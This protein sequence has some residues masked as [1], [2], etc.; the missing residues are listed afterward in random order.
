MSRVHVNY[1]NVPTTCKQVGAPTRSS[2]S[3]PTVGQPAPAVQFAPPGRTMVLNVRKKFT[4]Q[5]L[6]KWCESPHNVYVGRAGVVFIPIPGAPL[7][8]GKIKS[9]GLMGKMRV[10][11]KRYPP[12]SS[13]WANPFKIP[14][15][16]KGE[17]ISPAEIYR[18]H[19]Q[20]VSSYRTYIIKKIADDPSTYDISKLCDKNLGCWCAPKPCHADVLREICDRTC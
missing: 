2:V 18:R 5:D 17:I 16:K 15:V 10:Q 13:I 9:N 4:H 14:R 1:A 6:N 11:R 12:T 8:P 7:L 20:V 19:A 3:S